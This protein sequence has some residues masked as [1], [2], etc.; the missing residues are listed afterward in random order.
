MIACPTCYQQN[1]PDA[2]FCKDCR[3]PLKS[4]APTCPNGHL[5]NE[6]W[7]ECAYCRAEG[8]LGNSAVYR[9]TTAE[10][11]PHSQPSAAGRTTTWE[12][13]PV[14]GRPT[15]NIPPA[16]S[17]PRLAQ[18]PAT[19]QSGGQA[20]Q[21]PRRTVYA[22]ESPSPGEAAAKR[23]QEKIIAILVTYTWDP[24]GQIF[25]IRE[26]R[27]RIGADS[28][29]C[30]VA[31]GHRVYLEIEEPLDDTLS[32]VHSIITVWKKFTI[33]DYFSKNGTYVDG[34]R[35]EEQYYPLK[36]YSEIR[37]GSTVWTFVILDKEKSAI[38]SVNPGPQPN[39]GV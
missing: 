20:S 17:G 35:V 21:L 32:A 5:M 33:S 9:P 38:A 6:T 12:T 34:E 18:S 26:G 13:P 23:A 2:S 27:N 39:E 29:Q 8:R 25:P 36:N 1:P 37:T 7:T 24:A 31:L 11:F 19:P 3:T 14:P 16:T 15:V 10:V 30:E 22:P 28:S 4:A